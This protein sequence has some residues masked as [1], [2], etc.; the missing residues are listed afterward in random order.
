VPE[1]V[2]PVRRLPHGEGLPLPAYATPG[3]AGMD[4]VAAVSE[5]L[6]IAPGARAAVP[7]GLE[8]A[9]PEG[10]ELQVRA[11][12]GLALH[13]GLAVLNGPG[14]IDSDYRGEVKVILANLGA[15]DVVVTRGMRI[16]QLV[17][18]PVTRARCEAADALDSTARG[19]GGFGSTGTG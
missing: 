8:M 6:V 19:R 15:E 7:T 5:D 1:V 9:V 17:L 13:Q 3:A 11:R 18:A 4:V 12:S 16:A 2:L 14:T 10:Y